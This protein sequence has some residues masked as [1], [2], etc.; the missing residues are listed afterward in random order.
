MPLR[1]GKG[2]IGARGKQIGQ[3]GCG[4]GVLKQ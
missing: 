4:A 3:F 1:A 2:L